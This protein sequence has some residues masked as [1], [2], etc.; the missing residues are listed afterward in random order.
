MEDLR[1]TSDQELVA[2]LNGAD[3]VAFTEIYKRYW[4]KPFTVAANKIANNG[5]CLGNR[6]K[7]IHQP[8]ESQE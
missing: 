1:S 5:G 3:H 2:L 8:L 6:S 7:Y 4:K